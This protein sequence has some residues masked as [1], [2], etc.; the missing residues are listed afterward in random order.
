MSNTSFPTPF[1]SAQQVAERARAAGVQVVLH[2]L[3]A[4]DAA[5]G[6]RGIACQPGRAGEFREG[7]ERAIEYAK[8]V[9]CP[10]LNALAGVRPRMC[11]AHDQAIET[12]VGTC[13]TPR[14][15]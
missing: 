4:G 1:G 2:N 11:R 9:G 14:A 12:L 15:S 10:R 7:V 13:A 3:P 5:K 8:A 6:D